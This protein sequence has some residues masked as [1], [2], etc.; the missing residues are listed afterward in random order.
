MDLEPKLNRRETEDK[1]KGTIGK[2]QRRHR[3]RGPDEV[4]D[5]AK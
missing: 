4:K 1:R 5:Q 3:F 2:E